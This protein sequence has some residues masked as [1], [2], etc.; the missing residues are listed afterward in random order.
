MKIWFTSDWHL[1]HENVIKYCN[2]PFDNVYEM[3]KTIINNHN[4]LVSDE[5]LVYFL[6]DMCFNDK[7]LKWLENIN[8]NFIYIRGNHDPKSIR[9]ISKNQEIIFL[10][11]YSLYLTHNPNNIQGNHTLNVVGHVHEKWLYRKDINAVNVGVDVN[12]FKP[13]SLETILNYI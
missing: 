5:D 1:S 2:R 4:E 11:N 8:G 13:V 12:N 9:K 7:S 6:G 3:N 10:N